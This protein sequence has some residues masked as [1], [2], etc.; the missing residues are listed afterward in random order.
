MTTSL[1]WRALDSVRGEF[2][3]ELI[4]ASN[5]QATAPKGR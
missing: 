3:L 4:L 2:I 5:D 1:T